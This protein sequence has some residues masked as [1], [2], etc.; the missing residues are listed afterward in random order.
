MTYAQKP[1]GKDEFNGKSERPF[2]IAYHNEI[3]KG[4][5]KRQ[6][7]PENYSTFLLDKINLN[8]RVVKSNELVM[9]SSLRLQYRYTASCK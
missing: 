2:W 5:L 8:L 9:T 1:P 4:A 3:C 6:P 7:F